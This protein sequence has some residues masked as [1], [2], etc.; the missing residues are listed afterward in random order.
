[1]KLRPCPF[2]GGAPKLTK[3]ENPPGAFF[4]SIQCKCGV[5]GPAFIHPYHA[6]QGWNRMCRKEDDDEVRNLQD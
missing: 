3:M 6:I 1:M 5:R 4:S 2:C